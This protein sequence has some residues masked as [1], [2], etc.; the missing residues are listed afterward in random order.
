MEIPSVGEI[1]CDEIRRRIFDG[2]YACGDRMNVDELARKL[3]TSKTPVREALGRLESEGLV[4]FKARMGWS[5][6]SLSMEEFVEF[7]ELQCALRYFISD[8]LLPFIDHIDFDLLNSI[9]RKLPQ[10]K[11]EHKYHELIRQNDLFHITIFS[12]YPNRLILRRLTEIDSI[13]RLQRVRF[14]E[15]ERAKFP[16]LADSA[17]IQ[18]QEIIEALESRDGERI[19]EVSHRHHESLLDAFKS[20]SQ[21]ASERCSLL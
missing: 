10:L 3:N 4:S 13:I 19:S 12:A 18:H 5:V 15:Q 1:I 2:Q 16:A 7:L 20:M 21:G 14:F 17:F 11:E 9:N 6:S 8:S